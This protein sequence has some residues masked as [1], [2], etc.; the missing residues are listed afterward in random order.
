MA[1]AMLAVYPDV[2]AAGA[3]IAGLPFGAATDV[4][5]AL[6]S[7]G[8][9]AN[10]PATM[11]GDHVRSAFRHS[12]PWPR[13]RSGMAARTT[14]VHISN[15][16]ETITQWINVHGLAKRPEANERGSGYRRR[17]WCTAEGEPIVERYDI[18]GMTLGIALGADSNGVGYGRTGRYFVDVG[19]SSSRL[20]RISGGY[21]VTS[22]TNA[23]LQSQFTPMQ[24]SLAF[25]R[26]RPWPHHPL[27]TEA[28]AER[29]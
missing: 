19:V 29:L 1:N 10:K 25:G 5:E 28:Y 21:L 11:W 26:T 18:S 6:T 20:S 4:H 7:M 8:A 24:M 13:S 3:V 2:F 12:G 9:A 15:A 16:R 23:W 27:G 22:V 17:V 14:T